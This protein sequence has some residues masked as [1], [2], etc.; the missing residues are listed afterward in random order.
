MFILIHCEHGCF[1]PSCGFQT[2]GSVVLLKDKDLRHGHHF[3]ENKETLSQ[4]AE[5]KT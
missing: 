2:E 1:E 4:A 3:L 5:Q